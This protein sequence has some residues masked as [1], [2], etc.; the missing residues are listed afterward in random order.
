MIPSLRIALDG[1]SLQVPRTGVGTYAANLIEQLLLLDESLEILLFTE[2]S[3]PP[4]NF[5][6]GERVR[7]MNCL[8]SI[9]NNF[10]WSNF[11]VPSAL[12]RQKA[13]LFHSPGYTLPL[14]LRI[15]AVVS[16]HDVSY[17]AEPRWYPYKRGIT[18]RFWYRASALRADRIITISEFSRKEIVRVYGI[19]PEKVAMIYPGVDRRI[20]RPIEDPSTIEAFK[21]R[22]E[23][24]SDYLLFVGDIHPRRNLERIIE[25]F[26]LVKESLPGSALLEL[27]VVGRILDPTLKAKIDQMQQRVR[28]VR[29]VGYVPEVELPMFY[30]SA[31]AFI[32]TSFYEGFGLGIL[33]AMACRCPVIVARGT[34]CEEAGGAAAIAVDPWNPKATAEAITALITKPDYALRCAELGFDRA[35]EFCWSKAAKHTLALYRQLVGAMRL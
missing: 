2:E 7:V 35:S 19:A 15:P 13:D 22:Y 3:Q 20:F 9:R 11:T 26:A 17:E 8:P 21:K 33:E 10:L 31:R 4:L 6:G 1:R 14:R 27:M 25:A 24:R 23:I 5:Q 30:G 34:A 32:F 12:N 16:V 18:R 28:G 29:V